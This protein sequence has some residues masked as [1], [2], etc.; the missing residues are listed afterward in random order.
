MTKQMTFDDARKPALKHEK[1]SGIQAVRDAREFIHILQRHDGIWIKA[2]WFKLNNGWS[3][4]YTRHLKTLTD[5]AVI[6]GNLGYRHA[7]TCTEEAMKEYWAREQASL[8]Q[9]SEQ[10]Q[11]SYAY[12]HGIHGRDRS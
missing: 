1:K 11:K 9:R 10:L 6:S 5:G 3:P 12:Y 2:R 8:K 7:R 4:R